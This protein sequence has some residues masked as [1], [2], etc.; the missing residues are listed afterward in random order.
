MRYATV[1]AAAKTAI[2]EGKPEDLR[3]EPYRGDDMRRLIV[4]PLAQNLIGGLGVACLGW[5]GLYA[6][7][8]LTSNTLLWSAL[9]GLGVSCLVTLLRFF[10]DDLGLLGA[11]WRAGWKAGEGERRLLEM[12]IKE[13]EYNAL[14][15]S[16]IEHAQ[17]KVV[18]AE[19]YKAV[20]ELYT[21]Q[22]RLDATTMMEYWFDQPESADK[23]R[24]W[25]TRDVAMKQLN[26]SKRQ[27]EG[28][29]ALLLAAGVRVENNR[30]NACAQPTLEDAWVQMNKFYRRR[31]APEA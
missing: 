3:T 17:K 27:W 24:E 30:R 21:A 11:A 13:L 26:W 20:E 19:S 2:E 28:A 8:V 18:A 1:T 23:A 9:L 25:L 22:E 15:A 10:A 5:I 14:M 4:I 29:M 12:R 6:A 7:D 31:V 16:T